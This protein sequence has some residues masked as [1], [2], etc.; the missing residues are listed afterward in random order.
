MANTSETERTLMHRKTNIYT[1]D[2]LS[3]HKAPDN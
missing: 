3:P 1:S 2:R